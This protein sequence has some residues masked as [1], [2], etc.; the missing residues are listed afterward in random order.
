MGP[1]DDKDVAAKLSKLY[2][3]HQS[4]ALSKAEFENAK[5]R[6]LG[7]EVPRMVAQPPPRSSQSYTP[8]TKPGRFA[9]WKRAVLIVVALLILLPVLGRFLSDEEPDDNNQLAAVPTEPAVSMAT[10]MAEP[11]ATAIPRTG[12]QTI[13]LSITVENDW[14]AWGRGCVGSGD[15]DWASS[16]AGVA[17][18]PRGESG[19]VQGVELGAGQLSDDETMCQWSATLTSRASDTYTIHVGGHN[20][21]CHTNMMLP[22]DDGFFAAVMLNRDGVE[23]ATVLEVSDTGGS[24]VAAP[25]GN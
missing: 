23:C 18:A 16:D 19:T 25:T 13:R 2:D 17:V 20:A 4:G 15:V 8:D 21:Y 22:T 6:L 5:R 7:T 10:P 11:T 3:L 1:I 24:P 9:D 12:I 14:K